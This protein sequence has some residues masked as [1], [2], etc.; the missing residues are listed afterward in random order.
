MNGISLEAI[1]E[2]GLLW[3]RNYKPARNDT[4]QF[5]TMRK[6]VLVFLVLS[7]ALS[8]PAQVMSTV[9]YRDFM[10][11]LDASGANVEP[12]QAKRKL[13]SDAR[14]SPPLLLG[15]MIQFEYSSV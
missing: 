7:T 8:C 4:L 6:A 10:K 11:R 12:G 5:R 14:A 3:Q 9:E 15:T 13:S 1:H 2:S